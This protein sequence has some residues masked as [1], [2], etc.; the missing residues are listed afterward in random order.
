MSKEHEK[1]VAADRGKKNTFLFII[2]AVVLLIIAVWF[3][4]G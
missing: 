3:L 1:I 4:R 2:L